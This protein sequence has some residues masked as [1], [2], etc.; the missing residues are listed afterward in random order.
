MCMKQCVGPYLSR[1]RASLL[2]TQGKGKLS[3]VTSP[4]LSLFHLIFETQFMIHFL[5]KGYIR[6]EI[7]IVLNL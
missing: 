1:D 2:V 7:I 4:L 5:Q 3:T 6:R